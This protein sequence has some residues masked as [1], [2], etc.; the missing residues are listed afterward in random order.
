[1]PNV[2]SAIA[3]NEKKYTGEYLMNIGIEVSKTNQEPLT[4]VVLEITAVD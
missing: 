1:M 3:S 2:K 4:S